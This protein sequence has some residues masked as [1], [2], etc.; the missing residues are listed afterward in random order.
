MPFIPQLLTHRPHR[1]LRSLKTRVFHLVPSW[2][3]LF[4]PQQP[5]QGVRL[6]AVRL[7]VPF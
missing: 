2:T 1:S 6:V 5:L 4:P 7:C 3:P